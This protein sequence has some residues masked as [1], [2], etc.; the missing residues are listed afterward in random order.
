M[1]AAHSITR[2]HKYTNI[3]VRAHTNTHMPSLRCCCCLRWSF[4]ILAWHSFFVVIVIALSFHPLPFSL[5]LHSLVPFMFAVFVVRQSR[6]LFMFHFCPFS[7]NEFLFACEFIY[8]FLSAA[9]FFPRKFRSV[10]WSQNLI[11]LF[12]RCS[13]CCCCCIFCALV[14]LMLPLIATNRVRNHLY[15]LQFGFW[16]SITSFAGMHSCGRW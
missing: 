14:S 3:R 6:A 12:N 8:L 10:A 1:C 15:P 2:L 4:A 9:E 13:C 16:Y 11:D 5:R 7:A